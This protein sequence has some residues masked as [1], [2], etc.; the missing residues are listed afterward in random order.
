MSAEG[1]ITFQ[2]WQGL[3]NDFVMLLGEPDA[4]SG[5]LARKICSRRLGVGAD[6]LIYLCTEGDKLRMKIYN[7]DGSLAKMCGNGIRCLAAMACREGMLRKG[8]NAEIVTDSGLRRAEVMGERPYFVKV[9]MGEPQILSSSEVELKS[10]SLCRSVRVDMGNPHWVIFLPERADLDSFP[11]AAE[12]KRLEN[13]VEGGI[14]VEFVCAETPHKLN[15]RVWERG[16]GETMACGTGA[17]AVLAAARFQKLSSAKADVILPGGIL[18][19]LWEEGGHIF[20]TGGAEQVFEGE[21]F[22]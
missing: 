1:K 20:M 11:V 4:E 3:G 12:G 19:I 21:Y 2:K 8:E 17:C 7:A 5:K 9:D 16:V 22:V 13:S 15:M 10:G 18:Q 14:N 6:G